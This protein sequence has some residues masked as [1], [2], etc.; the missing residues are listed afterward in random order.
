MSGMVAGGDTDGLLWFGD[1]ASRA[2]RWTL[3][4][5]KSLIV[6]LHLER[7]DIVTRGYAGQISR[8]RMPQSDAAIDTCARPP[9]RY[10]SVMRKTLPKLAFRTES[11]RA[12]SGMD[13][14]RVAGAQE[15]AAPLLEITRG[16]A[17]PVAA[18]LSP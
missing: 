2:R 10:H 9:L 11:L 18:V 6:G 4:S 13:L 17:C 16:N 1:A 15:T 3:P 14:A 8:W 7:T 12:L 5:H